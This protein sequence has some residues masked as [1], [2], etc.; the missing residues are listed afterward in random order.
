MCP[1]LHSSPK[2]NWHRKAYLHAIE[3]SSSPEQQGH[4]QPTSWEPALAPAPC[5]ELFG[6][7][8]AGTGLSHAMDHSN[9]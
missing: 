3:P 4:I 9:N 1:G 6:R 8:L 7:A 5:Q 2:A